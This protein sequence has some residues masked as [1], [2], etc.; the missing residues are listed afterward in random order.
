MTDAQLYFAAGMPTAVVLIGIL[1]NV[2]YFV[3]LN[4]LE[5]NPS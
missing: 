5:E 1:V 4:G 2:G 3:T